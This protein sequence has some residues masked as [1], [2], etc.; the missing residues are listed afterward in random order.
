MSKSKLF[1]AAIFALFIPA[2]AGAASKG[3]GGYE[4]HS[5]VTVLPK[6]TDGSAG[7]DATYVYFGDWPQTIK[8]PSVTVNEKKTLKMGTNVYYQGDDGAWYAKLAENAADG[9]AFYSDNSAVSTSKSGRSKYFKVEPVKWRVLS[10]DYAG[11]G[12]ALLF[13]ENVLDSVPFYTSAELSANQNLDSIPARAID[14][15]TSALE[16][17][18]KYSQIHAWLNGVEYYSI[19]KNKTAKKSDYKGKGFLQAAFNSS[20]QK[21]IAANSSDEINKDKVFLLSRTEVADLLNGAVNVRYPSDY[22]LAKGTPSGS[23]D[24]V[25]Y[26]LRTSSDARNMAFGI[27]HGTVSSFP[28]NSTGIGF[29]PAVAVTLSVDG[30]VKVDPSKISMADVKKKY[31][32]KLAGSNI[33]PSSPK[34]ASTGMLE[35]KGTTVKKSI[36]YSELFTY[37]RNAAISDLYVSDHAVTQPEYE[38]YCATL[39]VVSSS[40]GAVLPV[41]WATWYDAVIYCNLRSIAE[42]LVPA[43]YIL[44][45]GTKLC[46]PAD[47]AL[48]EPNIKINEQGKY[49]YSS[50]ETV[51][52]VL[53]KSLKLDMSADGYRLPTEVEWEYMAMFYGISASSPEWCWDWWVDSDTMPENL[54]VTGA[55]SG[56]ERVVRGAYN[57]NLDKQRNLTLRESYPTVTGTGFRVVR[58]KPSEEKQPL[59][60]EVKV[61][62]EGSGIAAAKIK[63]ARPGAVVQLESKSNIGFDFDAYR[64]KD[65]NGKDVK[66]S[67][68]GSFIMPESNASVSAVFKKAKP[69]PVT[70]AKTE[71]V[72]VKP[73]KTEACTGET[74]SL[75]FEFAQGYDIDTITVTDSSGKAVNVSS[76]Y[77]FVMPM[78]GANVSVSVQQFDSKNFVYV[79]GAT[80]KP[81]SN[82]KVFT[83]KSVTIK[84][85]YVCKHE[86]TQ[87]EWEKYMTY[88]GV[89]SIGSGKGQSN[90][91]NP[92][93]PIARNGKGPDFPA[94]ALNW[95]EAV[96]YCN[97]R[98]IDE[99]FEPVYYMGNMEKNPAQWEKIANSFVRHNSAGKYYI[100]DTTDTSALA[101]VKMD[102]NANGYRLPTEAEWEYLA[103][104]GKDKVTS[105]GTMYAGSDNY[106]N[107][108]WCGRVASNGKAH[109]V[110]QKSPNYLGL[111]DMS[112]NVAEWTWNDIHRGGSWSSVVKSDTNIAEDCTVYGRPADN[113]K[114]LGER[115]PIAMAGLRVVRTKF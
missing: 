5:T 44:D 93:C 12:K 38:K 16:N 25:A 57:K 31:E 67:A 107:V 33:T 91:P 85:M 6:G 78:G 86:T 34:K 84:D 39:A 17:N 105:R 54:A 109:E 41:G 7:P 113:K 10:K 79:P 19:E 114:N 32:T 58:T 76:S 43:Y 20:A 53:D 2:F 90:D 73:D 88:Y 9:N 47:W 46:D 1:A 22:A 30:E 56:E 72:T 61:D 95:F 27:E 40:K 75:S 65:A 108:G 87:A 29:V 18:Y 70:V 3:S 21:L 11:S 51:S 4:F 59:S 101:K 103:R 45:N 48:K 80:V 63:S 13:A 71:N 115:S 94:Y 98:S 28:V 49:A 104:G 24:G 37:G 55:E 66:V 50:N 92:Y 15:K 36:K 106:N 74:V 89:A 110:M 100:N 64:V 83:G 97:L 111:Y 52:G 35:V 82:S 99:G 102:Q 42:G 8:D 23:Y 68:S 62:P 26:Y 96:I 69:Y 77:S 81:I 112:G 60:V 14:K